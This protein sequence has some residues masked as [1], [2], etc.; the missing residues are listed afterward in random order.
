M[1][2]PVIFD[3]DIGSDIDDT[4]A[5]AQILKTPELDVKLIATDRDDTVYRTKLICKYLEA[6]NCTHIPVGMGCVQEHVYTKPRQAAWVEDYDLDAYSGTLHKDGVDAIIQTIMDAPEPLTLICV[7]PMPNIGEALDREPAIA[8]R[9]HFVGMHGCVYKSV[10]GEGVFPEANVVND[11]AASKKVFTAPWKSMIITPQDSCSFVK[12]TGDQYQAIRQSND[13]ALKALM[14]NYNIWAKGTTHDPNVASSVLFDTVAVYLAY[15]T[16]HLVMKNMG[17]RITDEGV[18]A[19]APD[20]QHMDVAL[21]W[22]DLDA[23]HQY[24][25][26]RLLSPIVQ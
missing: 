23:F 18:T 24:L 22:T 12:L 9:T 2:I 6:V 13:P 5:L 15:T 10:R 1:P 25:T 17:I 7:G 8:E 4:W 14:D 21:D 20:A 3:T 19:P 26:E 11:I 16:K